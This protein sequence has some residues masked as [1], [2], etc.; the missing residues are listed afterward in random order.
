MATYVWGITHSF[1]HY[2]SAYLV[3]DV[4]LLGDSRKET[5]SL[6][7]GT[8]LSVPSAIKNWVTHFGD[9]QIFE[10]W[11]ELSPQTCDK[12]I[13]YPIQQFRFRNR[14]PSTPIIRYFEE[15]QSIDDMNVQHWIHSTVSQEAGCFSY[16]QTIDSKIRMEGSFRGK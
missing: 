15:N 12:M 8:Y 5:I 11:V 13:S 3:K 1:R 16:P 7:R 6:P 4:V 2:S 9:D 10:L 14:F